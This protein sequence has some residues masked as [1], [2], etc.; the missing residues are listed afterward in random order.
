MF[1]KSDMS[2]I[3]NDQVSSPQNL[4]GLSQE[5]TT[6]ATHV[7]SFVVCSSLSVGIYSYKDIYI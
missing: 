6:K 3:S 4:V 5:T 7:D 1:I 2:Y